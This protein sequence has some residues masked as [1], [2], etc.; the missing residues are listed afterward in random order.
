MKICSKCKAQFEIADVDKEFYDRISPV[1]PSAG[2]TQT[3]VKCPIPEPNSCPKCRSKRRLSFRNERKIYKRRCDFTGNDIISSYSPDKFIKVFDQKEWWGD[4]W[5]AKYYG[6]DFDFQRPFFEQF[7]ELLSAVPK[8]NLVQQGEM[9]NSAYC[10]CAAYNKNCYL[11][12][13]S[14]RDEDCSYG[15]FA[16]DCTN[17][18]DNYNIAHCELAYDCVDCSGCYE[19]QSCREVYNSSSVFHSIDCRNC[20]FLFACVGLRGQKYRVL[21]EPVTKEVFQ[22]LMQNRAKQKEILQKLPELYLSRPRLYTNFIQSEDFSGSYIENSKNAHFC[23]DVHGLED[24]KF[25]SEMRNS[26]NVYDVDCYGV[27][28]NN[29][30]LYEDEGVGHGVFQILFSKLIWGGSA[31]VLYSYECFASENL[32]GCTGLKKEQYCILNKKY[33]SEE[34][35][36]LVQKIIAHMQK[37][38]EF[39]EFFPSL[40]SPYGY[41]ETLAIEHWPLN[42][43]EAIEKRFNWSDYE[44]P[45]PAVAKIVQASKLP[46]SIDQVPDDI[47]DWAIEC[48]ESRKPFKITKPELKFYR[49][50][51]IP[52]PHFHPEIRY[53]KRFNLRNPR[54]LWRRTCDNDNCQVVFDSPYAPDRPEK[55]FCEK[56]FQAVTC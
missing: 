18:I 46:D 20:D 14:A 30:L 16:D 28:Q 21:N 13:A 34:Y 22:D 3:A 47:L 26:K 50:N 1:F 43:N 6:R 52:L 55:V 9:D 36:Q 37:T 56:C 42:K 32:F 2:S 24:C 17:C 51:N 49:K 10:H 19:T 11:L 31:N 44:S 40:I 5:D 38:N 54:Q 12:F 7:A 41:N 33:S 8:M 53:A 45:A 35:Y 4:S 15:K 23:Y 25:C 27:T 29:E 48:P 39:G